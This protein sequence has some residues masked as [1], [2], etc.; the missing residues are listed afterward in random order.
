MCVGEDQVIAQSSVD[1]LHH[2]PWLNVIFR[3]NS[4]VPVCRDPIYSS[5]VEG[6]ESD[7]KGPGWDVLLDHEGETS[8]AVNEEPADGVS[9]VLDSPKG[10][11]L[12]TGGMTVKD[13]D[14]VTKHS[15][16]ARVDHVIPDGQ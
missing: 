9:L 7:Q 15:I 13:P 5:L 3:E 2:Y 11:E 12:F 16:G 6:E 4:T 10:G 14:A 8:A 1:V